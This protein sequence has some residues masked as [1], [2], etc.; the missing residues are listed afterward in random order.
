MYHKDL[1]QA[2]SVHEG[3]QR[4]RV[5][6][7][8]V[9]QGRA[10]VP[11]APGYKTVEGLACDN[12]KKTKKKHTH[13][14]KCRVAGQLPSKGYLISDPPG[15]HAFPR[16]TQRRAACARAVH[17]HAGAIWV[18]FQ[19]KDTTA[20]MLVRI[21]QHRACLPPTPRH[22]VR[23]ALTNI[24]SDICG[25]AS[26]GSIAGA[27]HH[28]EVVTS[29]DPDLHVLQGRSFRYYKRSSSIWSIIFF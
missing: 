15:P 19:S 7:C 18:P 11:A 23:I 1:G 16:S 4:P 28:V 17:G 12:K 27:Q 2:V 29:Q 9:P 10:K 13:R 25:H 6:K 21:Q 20:P 3:R 14:I 22:P 5:G 26:N 24:G 8:H